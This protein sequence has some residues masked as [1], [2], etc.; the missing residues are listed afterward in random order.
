MNL[1]QETEITNLITFVTNKLITVA[2]KVINPSIT[3]KIDVSDDV[4]KLLSNAVK[5]LYR[6]CYFNKINNELVQ[7]LFSDN[8]ELIC[9]WIFNPISNT[10]H[11]EDLEINSDLT[12]ECQAFLNGLFN[13]IIKHKNEFQSVAFTNLSNQ[14]SESTTSI[15]TDIKNYGTQVS[16]VFDIVKSVQDNLNS[17]F[18]VEFS[19]INKAVKEVKIIQTWLDAATPS[20]LCKENC[21]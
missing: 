8:I 12:N 3:E 19:E 4:K 17:D 7:Q 13:Y 14:V 5:E 20:F 15:R 21:L 6:N 10:Y 9:G 11:N 2:A 18:S 1:I 16:A